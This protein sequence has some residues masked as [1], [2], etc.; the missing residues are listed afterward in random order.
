MDPNIIFFFVLQKTGS[1]IIKKINFEDIKQK[2][3]LLS[4]VW[5]LCLFSTISE[6]TWKEISLIQKTFNLIPPS[7][8]RMRQ[9][10][11]CKILKKYDLGCPKTGQKSL[12]TGRLNLWAKYLE[13]QKTDL[14]NLFFFS[15]ILLVWSWIDRQAFNNFG[16]RLYRLDV[17]GSHAISCS[18]WKY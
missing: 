6:Q 3:L 2:H 1:G 11:F 13:S 7:S 14:K 12:L 8:K 16:S 9:K 17:N 4:L 10:D 15:E 5:S 18:N